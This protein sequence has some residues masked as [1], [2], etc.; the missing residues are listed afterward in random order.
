M[1]KDVE[2]FRVKVTDIRKDSLQKGS[3]SLEIWDVVNNTIRTVNVGLDDQIGFFGN[4]EILIGWSKDE[5]I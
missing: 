3:V 5:Q 4:V 2:L 1:Y